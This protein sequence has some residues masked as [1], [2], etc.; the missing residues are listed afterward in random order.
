MYYYR[1][2]LHLEHLCS[3]A[4]IYILHFT[5]QQLTVIVFKVNKLVRTWGSGL[6]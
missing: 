2:K 5:K 6:G 4:N 1:G 3:F